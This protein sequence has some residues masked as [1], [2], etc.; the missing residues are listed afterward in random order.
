MCL[1]SFLLWAELMFISSFCPSTSVLPALRGL[2]EKCVII[3][4]HDQRLAHA[5]AYTRV[6]IQ[7]NISPVYP[8]NWKHATDKNE[9]GN[10]KSQGGDLSADEDCLYLVI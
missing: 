3:T 4:V 10:K 2:C 7:I 1:I 5:H 6:H 9:L 8:C